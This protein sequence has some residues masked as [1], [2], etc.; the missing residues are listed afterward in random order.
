MK[1]KSTPIIII[2]NKGIGRLKIQKQVIKKIFPRQLTH[3]SLTFH[4]LLIWGNGGALDTHAV[5]LDRVGTVD[6]DLVVC[7]VTVLDAQVKGV[8]LHIKEGQDK[9]LL[10]EVPDDAGHL[11]SQHLHHGST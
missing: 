9:L 8:E 5:L 6:G 10:N 4:S 3:L 1:I 11:I 2:E 7:G